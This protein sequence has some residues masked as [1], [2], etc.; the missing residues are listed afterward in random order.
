MDMQAVK[1]IC[2]ELQRTSGKKD[3]EAI[4]LREKDNECFM[5]N[6]YN[7]HYQCC[8]GNFDMYERIVNEVYNEV[9]RKSYNKR[10]DD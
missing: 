3:K 9:F 10:I 5:L 1:N 2:D 8:K 7:I 6:K 4:L